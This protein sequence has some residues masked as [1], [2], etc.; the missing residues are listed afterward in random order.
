MN[1][2]LPSGVN[3]C[4]EHIC[5]RVME[6]LAWGEW[7]ERV[8]TLKPELQI[9]GK[10]CLSLKVLNSRIT[11]IVQIHPFA[12]IGLNLSMSVKGI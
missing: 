6:V 7:A 8:R 10:Y 5:P 4:L 1:L 3:S 11:I 12:E 2:I 9:N